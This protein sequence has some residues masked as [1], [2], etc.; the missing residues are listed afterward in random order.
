LGNPL[1]ELMQR[2]VKISNR[3]WLIRETA[4]CQVMVNDCFHL[5]FDHWTYK[6]WLLGPG[7]LRIDLAAMVEHG[8]QQI[9]REVTVV[10]HYS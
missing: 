9:E 10:L 3:P 5:W 1:N 2:F 8:L 7:R 6:C 4:C